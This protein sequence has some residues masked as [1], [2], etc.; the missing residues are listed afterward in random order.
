MGKFL[1]EFKQ[2][3]MRGNVLD[4]AVGVIIGGAFGKIV[5]SVVDDII[6]PPIGWLIGGVNFSDL[7]TWGGSARLR[8]DFGQYSL[9]SITGYETLESLN[10]GDIDGGFGAAFLPVSGP[11]F[12]PFAAESAD[13]DLDGVAHASSSGDE[14]RRPSDC[15]TGVGAVC[16]RARPLGLDTAPALRA[17]T[18]LNQRD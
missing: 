2:F 3:A 16:S 1:N 8:W 12:I 14:R 7:E 17:R 15:S 5:S 11:G 10:R 18:R 4:M 6:M 13:G 9:Y